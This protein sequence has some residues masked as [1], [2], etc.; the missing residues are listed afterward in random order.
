MLVLTSTYP[1]W[2]RDTEPSF[3]HELSSRLTSS[4]EVFLL[5]PHAPGALST[6]S[7]NQVQVF[8]YRYAPAGLEIL[9]QKGGI[10]AN[11]KARPW[12][13]LLLP[14]FL[15]AQLVA[16]WRI[17][18]LVKPDLIHA[19]WIIPQGFV[20]AI[21]SYLIE[22]PPVLVTSHGGDLFGLRSRLM[23]SIKSWVARRFSG[24]TVVSQPMVDHALKLGVHPDRISVIPMGVDF[25]HRFKRTNSRRA[26]ASL[27]FVGRLVEKKGVSYLLDAMPAVLVSHPEAVL[28]IVGYGPELPA[29]Q[30]KVKNLSIEHSVRFTGALHQEKLPQ[31]YNSAT[32]FVA[33][34]VEAA[35]GDLEG[36]PVALMEAVACGCPLLA[37]DIPV[38]RN[39]FGDYA[40]E[41]LCD[42]RAVSILARRIT[43]GLENPVH[44]EL[45]LENLRQVMAGYLDWPIIS[46]KYRLALLSAMQVGQAS[47]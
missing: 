27:L 30:D 13:W 16:T 29:L 7:I 22:L 37:G 47:R 4:F 8:R 38:L 19:H 15:L 44:F 28:T 26:P 1:R 6:E 31:L 12:L 9:C 36:F 25:Q 23:L 43:K 5:S 17:I 14:L 20:L 18:K 40:D 21:L 34:F 11:L 33:P 39:A 45:L 35:N 32:L 10:M 46:E 2:A 3:V 42:P 24:V 41:L